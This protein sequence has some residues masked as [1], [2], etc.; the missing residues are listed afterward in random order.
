MRAQAGCGGQRG[1]Q[2]E[3]TLVL[4]IGNTL[5]TDEGAGVHAIRR[6]EARTPAVAGVRFLDGGTLSFTLAGPIS[7]ASR[8]IVIDAAELR[9]AP[10]S[11]ETFVQDG[12]DAFLGARGNCSV[13]EVGLLDLMQIA[14]LTGCLPQR[15]ALIGIQPA[16][17]DWGE[18]PTPSVET[19][20]ELACARALELIERWPA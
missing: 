15:R 19:G 12:M 13:H 8:L 9:R 18:R 6:L 2:T 14:R 3:A 4:G 16:T 7:Q 1:V 20:I 5:L 11:V 10:G 17:I